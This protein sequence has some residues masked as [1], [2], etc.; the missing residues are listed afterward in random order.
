MAKRSAL[1]HAVLSIIC[2]I[3]TVFSIDVVFEYMSVVLFLVP[4]LLGTLKFL[5]SLV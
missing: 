4:F 2:E 5:E 3:G 1:L